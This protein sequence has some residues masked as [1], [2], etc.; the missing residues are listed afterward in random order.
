MKR[1]IVAFAVL[2]GLLACLLAQDGPTSVGSD[3]VARPR[4]PAADT[5]APASSAPDSAPAAPAPAPA[6]PSTDLP[7]IPSK[8]APKPKDD[9]GSSSATFSADTSLV[10]VDVAVVDNKNNFVPALPRNDF[11]ILEDNVPQ[12][13]REFSMGQAPMTVALVIEFSRRFQWYGSGDWYLTLQTAYAFLNT[14]KR[15]DYVA[16]IRYDLRS[17]IVQD[18]TNDRMKLQQALHSFV[19]PDFSE[20]NLF[21]VLTDTADRMSK[22]QG[23][24]SILILTSGIDTFSK[25]TFDQTRRKLQDSGVPIYSIG[26]L[27]M[28]NPGAAENINQLQADNA[29]KT[30]TTETGGQAFFPRWP[31]EIGDVFGAIQGAMRNQ[32]TLAYA[33][34][35]QEKDGKFRKITVQL[36][37]PGTNQPIVMKDEKGKPIKY[38]IV[39]KQGYTAPRA[40]E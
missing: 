35:N 9:G 39:A 20:A 37:D 13:I 29:M 14:M 19:F 11:R 32:Y 10:T 8:L 36:I 21:D 23:R 22:I 28:L 16:V 24:K 18:F 25:I 3:T 12:T 6:P 4:K 15:D 30:F 31:A 40:V 17:Q 2:L 1:L 27:T 7:K 26:L 33:P 38:S 34:S 5:S